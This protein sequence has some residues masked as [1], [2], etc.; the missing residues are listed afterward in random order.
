MALVIFLQIA[1]MSSFIEDSSVL[2]AASEFSLP[3][4]VVCA[5]RRASLRWAEKG[6]SSV[7]AQVAVDALILRQ[8]LSGG[9]FEV[10]CRVDSETLSIRYLN[11]CIK[12]LDSEWLF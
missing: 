10:S 12:I 3:Q 11:L 4:H 2:V 1:L 5:G 6:G 7:S 9:C 8:T